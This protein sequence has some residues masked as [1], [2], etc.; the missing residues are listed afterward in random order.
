MVLHRNDGSV[1]APLLANNLSDP[2][3]PYARYLDAQ[4]PVQFGT[5][6]AADGK[7]PLHYSLI[8]PENFDP[9]KRYPVVVY[10]YGGPAAQTVL[11]GWAGRSDMLFNQYLAQH[12]YVVF[13]LDN[14]GTPR[15]GRAFGGSLYEKQG[16]VEVADQL[17]GVEWLKHQS[18]VDP[19]HIGVY[20]WSNGGYMTLMLLAEGHGAYVCGAAGG[21]V[22]DWA[23]YDT[24]YTERYM[25]LPSANPEGYKNARVL[26]HLDGLVGADAPKLLLIHGMA[27][28]NVLFTNST[29]LMSALQAKGQ[30]FELMTY[31]GAK[32]GLHGMALLQRYRVTEDF[33]GRCLGN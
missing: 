5:I 31:P 33:F 23:L 1:I 26:E 29:Q 22:T 14:R 28:D 9:S 8:T 3:H 10:V 11:D 12:G 30:P 32:H 2:D 21:P 27:D 17:K 15:R 18:Y 4:R 13:S 7:T 20:G 24:H 19:S 25:N 6:T 16:T